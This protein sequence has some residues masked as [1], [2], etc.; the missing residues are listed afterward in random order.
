[1]KTQTKKKVVKK[2][3]KSCDLKDAVLSLQNHVIKVISH[4]V[5]NEDTAK[6]VND[7]KA[8]AEKISNS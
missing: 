1:M 2:S 5:Q 4:V 6:I 7:I 8:D 3:P